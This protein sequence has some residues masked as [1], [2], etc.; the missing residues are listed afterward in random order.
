MIISNVRSLK[1]QIKLSLFLEEIITSSNEACQD[2]VS[3]MM[4]EF[5]KLGIPAQKPA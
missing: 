4:I 3:D 1:S 2:F 5:R